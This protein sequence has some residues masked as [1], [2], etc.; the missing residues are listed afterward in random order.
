MS[1]HH[2]ET[3]FLRH[4]ILYGVSDECRKL[5][6]SIAQVQHE[7]RCVKRV[8]AVTLLFPVLAIAG[9]AYGVILHANFPF[10]GADRVFMVLCELGLAS[11]ICSVGLAV[12]LTVYH[13][14]LNRLRRECRRSVIRLLE[15]HLGNPHTATS[16]THPRVFDDRQAFQ[17][18]NEASG[19]PEGAS[20]I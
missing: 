8:A 13:T 9:A 10:N 17:G 19:Y 2:T 18:A 3:A 14:K 5:E 1:E 6:R 4:L 12:L 15:S 11:L 20:L 7:V 16:P